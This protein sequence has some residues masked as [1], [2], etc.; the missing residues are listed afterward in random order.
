[1]SDYLES[2]IITKLVRGEMSIGDLAGVKPDWFCRHREAFE[3]VLSRAGAGSIPSEGLVEIRFP[4]W[5]P[6]Q[7][8]DSTRDI[9]DTFKIEI[10]RR[11]L[12]QDLMEAYGH[13]SGDN[14]D[15]RMAVE[16][17]A[18]GLRKYV[19][20]GEDVV[21]LADPD[22]RIATYQARV[23]AI[24]S[25]R[26]VGIPTPFPTLDAWT[27]GGL[28]NGDFY[29]LMGDTGV[30]KTWVALSVA[31]NGW[32]AG[33]AP[34]YVS[35]EGTEEAMGYRFDTLVSR[36]PNAKLFLGDVPVDD[37]RRAVENARQTNGIPFW[38]AMQG[39]RLEYTPG[40]VQL[41]MASMAPKLV[42]VDYLTLM[43]MPGEDSDEWRVAASISRH[44][45]ALALSFRVPVVGVIQGTR[46]SG[47][48]ST[49]ELGDIAISYA[50]ARPADMVLGITKIKG[51]LKIELLKGR[52]VAVDAGESSKPK[53]YV[54]TDWDVGKVVQDTKTLLI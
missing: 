49:L 11:W 37:Y 26:G 17:L 3:W 8:K 40:A 25:G 5:H 46:S 10:Q 16:K 54:S 34:L 22:R 24:Q 7:N 38:L 41:L 23:D 32:L 47:Q 36:I 29:L 27:H 20:D 18:L 30:G 35:L 45:K 48:K 31:I 15:T 42:V 12:D 19:A 50:I 33:H 14:C 13:I 9:L 28:Q 6:T 4:D 21:D 2:T 51:G 53:F 43:T 44:L 52:H 39:S 1:M